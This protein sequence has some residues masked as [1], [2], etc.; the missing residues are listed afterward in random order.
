MKLLACTSC[1]DMF[2]LT[3]EKRTCACKKTTGQYVDDTN[4]SVSGPAKVLGIHNS[5]FLR[6]I[7]LPGSMDFKIFTIANSSNCITKE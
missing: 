5:A 4:V 1:F 2:A 3:R 6:A 7:I